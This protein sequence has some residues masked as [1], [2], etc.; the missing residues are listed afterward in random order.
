MA[1]KSFVF[2]WTFDSRSADPKI[3]TFLDRYNWL[4]YRLLSGW[5]GGAEEVTAKDWR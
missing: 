5:K 1:L 4:G 3:D 2:V